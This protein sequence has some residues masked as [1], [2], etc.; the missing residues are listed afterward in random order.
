VADPDAL[1]RWAEAKEPRKTYD[2]D[3]AFQ[4]TVARLESA[5]Q[6]EAH[7]VASMYPD[8]PLPY[9][10]FLEG[11]A[12]LGEPDGRSFLDVGCGKGVKG[13]IAWLHGYEPVGGIDIHQPY[14]D[15][16]R[17]VLPAGEYF[18][19]DAT[20]YDDY[21]R[22]SVAYC[23]RPPM[24]DDVAQVMLDHIA[25]HMRPDSHLFAPT[26]GLDIEGAERAAGDVWRVG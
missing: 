3:E 1:V 10:M 9:D 13:A 2:L 11:L 12:I 26:W 4:R 20:E 18:C 8:I 5:L 24:A 21:E 23:Y 25:T 17:R 19:T 16:A 14:L 22:W 7:H 6:P 15:V